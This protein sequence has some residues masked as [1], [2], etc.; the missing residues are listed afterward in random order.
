MSENVMPDQTP[1]TAN[2]NEN[3]AERAGGSETGSTNGGTRRSKRFNNRYG[4]IT[5]TTHRDFAG[6]TP[7]IGRILGLC[8]ENVTKKINYD[9][10]CEKL[11]TY[12]MTEFKNGDAVFQITKEHSADVLAIFITNNKPNG[13]TDEE[14]QDSVSVEIHKEEIKE[15]VKELK[16]LKSNLKKLHSLIYGN[17][18]ESVQTMLKADE[19]Y[20]DKSKVFD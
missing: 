18:T 8:S 7:K 15:Y 1:P 10:F 20:E 13:L 14:K 19:E 4:S 17:C 6:N 5:G 9:L 12:I 3:N 16:I 2:E 11:G